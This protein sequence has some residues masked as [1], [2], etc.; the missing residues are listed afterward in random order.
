MTE[1]A[2]YVSE[3]TITRPPRHLKTSTL[4]AFNFDKNETLL[5]QE[6]YLPLQYD[7]EPNQL[8]ANCYWKPQ[9]E[10]CSE[11]IQEENDEGQFVDVNQQYIQV[12]WVE[13]EIQEGEED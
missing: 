4:V 11:T 13:E 6:G 9:Y 10:L 7:D 2:K 5:R 12:H 3:D 1:F 8:S